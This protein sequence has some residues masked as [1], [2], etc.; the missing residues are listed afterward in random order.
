[1][2]P[3]V[4]V[5]KNNQIEVCGST[6]YATHTIIV[7]P[8][9]VEA[10]VAILIQGRG[11]ATACAVYDKGGPIEVDPPPLGIGISLDETVERAR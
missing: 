7:N 3:V 4:T 11:W 2:K 8:E 5:N 10:L 1:M 6:E 9:H